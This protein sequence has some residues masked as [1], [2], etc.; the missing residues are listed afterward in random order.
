MKR[1]TVKLYLGDQCSWFIGGDI[2]ATNEEEA[3][4][5][6]R[7]AVAEAWPLIARHVMDTPATAQF[8][9]LLS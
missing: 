9:S 1:W 6:A 2:H 7:R 8:R 3:I 4:E 5:R